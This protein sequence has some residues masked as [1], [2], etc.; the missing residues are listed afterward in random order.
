MAYPKQAKQENPNQD[1]MTTIPSVQAP[2]VAVP[3]VISPSGGAPT[4]RSYDALGRAWDMT[5][6]GGEMF[7]RT[8]AR[9]M[10]GVD[11]GVVAESLRKYWAGA[12]R[13][14]DEPVLV[15]STLP[16]AEAQKYLGDL[17]A[18]VKS[19]LDEQLKSI[20]AE[21]KLSSRFWRGYQDY[22]EQMAALVARRLW[23]NY[24]TGSGP[25]ADWL[26]WLGG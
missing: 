20:P 15:P 24:I 17:S 14:S 7:R 22:P 11:T 8:R 2:G 18:Q 16:L 13:D 25:V 23:T 6:A 12:A 19:V 9:M 5:G 3:Q 1:Y 21:E 26:K 4:V 10:T